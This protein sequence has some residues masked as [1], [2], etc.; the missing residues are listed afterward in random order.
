MSNNLAYTHEITTSYNKRMKELWDYER[1]SMPDKEGGVYF[2]S[3]NNGLQNQD[4]IFMQ[5]GLD[6]EP[7]L[8]YLE[9]I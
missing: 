3:Y 7:E 6:A 4:A 1:Y 2:Y 5:K 9:R 8:F